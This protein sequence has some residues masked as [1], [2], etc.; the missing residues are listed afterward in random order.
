MFFYQI[1]VITEQNILNTPVLINGN[2]F[3]GYYDYSQ[4]LVIFYLHPIA[5]FTC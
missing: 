4:L 3:C 5:P 1:W 2:N